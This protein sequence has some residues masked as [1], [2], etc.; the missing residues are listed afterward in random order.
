[1]FHATVFSLI[2]NINFISVENSPDGRGK[3]EAILSEYNLE[4]RCIRSSSYR[5]DT[6][7][8]GEEVYKKLL[9]LSQQEV[10][11]NFDD[12]V[13]IEKKKADS[14]IDFLGNCLID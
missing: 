3:I 13:R 9:I 6:A 12:V 10:N 5:G 1:M 14:F 4:N 11:E 8:L 7:R 2:H